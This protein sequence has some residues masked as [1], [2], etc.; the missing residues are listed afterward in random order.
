MPAVREINQRFRSSYR[1]SQSAIS[2]IGFHSPDA[3]AQHGPLDITPPPDTL[4]RVLMD[5]TPTDAP[6]DWDGS[7]P[8]FAPVPQ[9][10]GVVVVEWGGMTRE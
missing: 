5:A 4:I 8:D 6:P 7:L 3:I 10:T 1:I 9:R 2:S